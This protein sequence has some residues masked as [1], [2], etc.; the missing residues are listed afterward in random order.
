MV[1]RPVLMQFDSNFIR[2]VAKSEPEAL[3]T[4]VLKMRRV[5]AFS[6]PFNGCECLIASPSP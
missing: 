5:L 2:L 6:T 3:A 4:G 1:S